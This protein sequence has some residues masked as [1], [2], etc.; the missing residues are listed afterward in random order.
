MKVFA[1]SGSFRL[2]AKATGLTHGTVKELVTRNPM[3]YAAAKNVVAAQALNL[4]SAA[5]ERA[6]NKLSNLDDPYR[7]TL[8][9]KIAG[10]GH[11]E[12]TGMMQNGITV[13]V[14]IMSEVGTK[15]DLLR[16]QIERERTTTGSVQPPNSVDTTKQS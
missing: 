15:L 9:G 13:Q 16:S 14:G 10:Q 11:L 3:G 1:M 6:A 7:L 5:Y 4:S 2:A 8:I 12:M